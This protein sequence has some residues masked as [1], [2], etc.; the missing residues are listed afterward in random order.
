MNSAAL[1]K[2]VLQSG[3]GHVMFCSAGW[4]C[5]SISCCSPVGAKLLPHLLTMEPAGAERPVLDST[6]LAYD[7]LR[8][9]LTVPSHR[10][11][12]PCRHGCDF[13]LSDC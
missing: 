5:R 4:A 11:V 7:M 3:S 12:D 8:Q 6:E 9:H 1:V 10:T 2:I 13:V